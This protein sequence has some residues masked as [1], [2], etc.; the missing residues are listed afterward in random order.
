MT[1]LSLAFTLVIVSISIAFSCVTVDKNHVAITYCFGEIT[2]LVL[3]PGFNFIPPFICKAHQI[4]TEIQIATVPKMKYETLD[5]KTIKFD[6]IKVKYQID[7]NDLVRSIEVSRIELGYHL[8]SFY[9]VR[10]FQPKI[11]SKIRSKAEKQIKK[12]CAT[13][14][15]SEISVADLENKIKARLQDYMRM[16]FQNVR[17]LSVNV[18]MPS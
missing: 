8:S 7:Q 18:N 15:L 14:L 6:N 1:K 5:N 12:Y 10:L 4:P 11:E 3:E 16:W 2:N 17:I 9:E 13:K